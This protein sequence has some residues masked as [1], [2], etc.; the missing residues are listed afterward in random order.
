[1]STFLINPTEDQEKIVK[2]F[3]EALEISFVKSDEKEEL[4]EHVIK[5]IQE[6]MED[7]EAGR[8]ITMDEFKQKLS[9]FK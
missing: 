6:G 4:P 7:F 9:I 2:A 3:L 8:Y 5:G 1:M